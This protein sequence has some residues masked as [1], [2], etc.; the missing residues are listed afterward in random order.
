MFTYNLLL[1]RIAD[2][3][4]LINSLAEKD[5]PLISE[6]FIYAHQNVNCLIKPY[7]AGLLI[8]HSQK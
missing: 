6:G 8:N 5:D 7:L 4:D 2:N 1:L 3:T